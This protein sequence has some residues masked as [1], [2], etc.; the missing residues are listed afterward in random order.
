MHTKIARA[1]RFDC[2]PGSARSLPAGVLG[3]PMNVCERVLWHRSGS[4]AGSAGPDTVGHRAPH[5]EFRRRKTL[6]FNGYA[7]QVGSLYTGMDLKETILER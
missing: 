3:P 1:A 4:A 5:R 6:M 2:L 7:D